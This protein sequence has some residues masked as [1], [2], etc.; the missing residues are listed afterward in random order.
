MCVC[1]CVCVCVYVYVCV[2]TC[3]TA[4]LYCASNSLNHVSLLIY[5]LRLRRV[6]FNETIPLFAP[7]AIR[8]SSPELGLSVDD[9]GADTTKDYT[10]PDNGNVTPQTEVCLM[11]C[12]R[13]WLHRQRFAWCS[14]CENVSCLACEVPLLYSFSAFSVCR[15]LPDWNYGIHFC[16]RF[17]FLLNLK[18]NEAQSARAE[19]THKGVD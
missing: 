1:V 7:R 2:C 11:H 15:F 14:V 19:S 4:T 17:L 10:S 6:H 8:Q 5:V 9:Y 3:V 12:V 13:K 16:P 18:Q